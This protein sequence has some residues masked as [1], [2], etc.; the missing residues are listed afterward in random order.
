LR[1][2]SS[3]KLGIVTVLKTDSTWVK[4][5]HEKDELQI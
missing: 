4:M 1:Y 5:K 3:E 2:K